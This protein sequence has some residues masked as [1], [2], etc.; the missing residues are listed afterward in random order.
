MTGAILLGATITV[1]SAKVLFPAFILGSDFDM[2]RNGCV[3]I[4]NDRKQNSHHS[5]F[6]LNKIIF[7]NIKMMVIFRVGNSIYDG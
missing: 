6:H 1:L 2:L 3:V 7:K 5:L 4:L